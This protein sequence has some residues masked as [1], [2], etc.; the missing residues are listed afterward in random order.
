MRSLVFAIPGDLATPSGGYAYDRRLIA[1]LRDLGWSVEHLPLAG[2]F[3]RP[4]AGSL[5]A[6][7]AALAALAEGTLVLIDGLAFGAMPEVAA[8]HA[9]R[10]RLVALVHHPLALETGLDAATA[11]ALYDSEARALR[12]ARHIVVTS[13]ET[14][15]ILTTEFGVAAYRLTVAV[16][17]TEPR[18]RAPGGNEPPHLVSVGSLIPRKGHDVLIDA[19]GGLLDLPWRLTIAGSPDADPAW[20]AALR[21][22][23]VEAGLGARITFAGAVPDT[24]SLMAS[25]DIFVLPSRYEG[26]GMVFAEALAQG[27]PI[28]AAR[29]GAV[30]DVVPESAGILVPVDD[31]EALSTA[32]RRLIADKALR[33][34]MAEGAYRAGLKLPGWRETGEIVAGALERAV[35]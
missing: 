12:Y 4:S 19:L 18:P 30:P 11:E 2:D 3:P 26:Y 27:L 20:A 7:D 25:A 1:E 28:V 21:A 24:A 33:R 23:A 5:A 35:G 29:A 8:A 31:A 32:L 16:P 9:A 34:R 14:A 15:R 13:P 22:R 6:A 10:L 17:G